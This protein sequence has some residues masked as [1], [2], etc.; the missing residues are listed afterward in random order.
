M[1]F[2]ELQHPPHMGQ[3]WSSLTRECNQIAQGFPWVYIL[4]I[5]GLVN[6][7][8]KWFILFFQKKNIPRTF[9]NPKPGMYWRCQ[10]SNKQIQNLRSYTY[11]LI[12][13]CGPR[14][15]F[16]YI[17]YIA[18]SYQFLK[19]VSSFSKPDLN[20]QKERCLEYSSS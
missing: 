8:H 18:P 14:S 10:N 16:G 11:T 7:T 1:F 5:T 6:R 20:F 19:N 4:K 12:C 9:R 3:P 15:I 13:L 2:H 17:W